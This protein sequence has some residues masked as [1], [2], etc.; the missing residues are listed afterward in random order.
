[1][2]SCG[3]GD[4][5]LGAIEQE[6]CKISRADFRLR[7]GHEARRL[8]LIPQAV[9]DA[10]LGAARA[11][12]ALIG[13]GTRHAHGF[14]PRDADV[15]LEARHARQAAIDDD[16]HALDGERGFGDGRREHDLALAGRVGDTARSC[17]AMSMAP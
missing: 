15:G 2:T 4:A 6:A 16:A 5:P 1:M 17:A 3:I 14:E 10:G 11:A 8:R 13:G 9:A 7:E 12:A